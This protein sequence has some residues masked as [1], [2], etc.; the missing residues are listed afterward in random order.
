MLIT[1]KRNSEV[2]VTTTKREAK[3]LEDWFGPEMGR[4]A[5]DYERVEHPREDGVGIDSRLTIQ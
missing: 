3:F 1:Y 5:F 4:I 2:L